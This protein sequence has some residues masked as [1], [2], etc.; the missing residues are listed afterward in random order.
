MKQ[1]THTHNSD[2]V[3]IHLK[4]FLNGYSNTEIGKCA[5]FKVK[6]IHFANRQHYKDHRN[7]F[8]DNKFACHLRLG[9]QKHDSEKCFEFQKYLEFVCVRFTI[10]TLK[11]LGCKNFT[12]WHAQSLCK[13]YEQQRTYRRRIKRNVFSMPNIHNLCACKKCQLLQCHLKMN[14]NYYSHRT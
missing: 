13:S 10:V 6:S 5:R 8:R 11:L 4:P 2:A 1:P 14:N 12:A 3:E 9:Q 7:I